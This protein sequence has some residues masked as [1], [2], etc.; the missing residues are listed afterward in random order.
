MFIAGGPLY[1]CPNGERAFMC[2]A[3]ERVLA[4]Y[5]IQAFL[6]GMEKL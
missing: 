4:F 6:G 1:S 2:L 3:N 5:L